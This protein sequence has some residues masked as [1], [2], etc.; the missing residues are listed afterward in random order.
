[1][2]IFEWRGDGDLC[3]RNSSFAIL[4]YDFMNN[5]ELYRA[6]I[7]YADIYELSIPTDFLFACLTH[8][9]MKLFNICLSKIL[10][11]LEEKS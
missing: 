3:F 1:M 6:D 11:N 7:L 4:R 9:V 10:K 2:N 8:K 5:Y